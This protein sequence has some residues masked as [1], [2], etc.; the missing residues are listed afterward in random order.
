MTGLDK[1]NWDQLK[2]EGRK[3]KLRNRFIM[4]DITELNSSFG[5]ERLHLDKA[6]VLT[7]LRALSLYEIKIVQCLRLGTWKDHAFSPIPLLV[8]VENCE[9]RDRIL[10]S[11]GKLRSSAGSN[12]WLKDVSIQPDHSKKE[13]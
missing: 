11:A 6:K 7:V 8:H 12:I 10:R 3:W 1:Y 5:H 13:I 4:C 2:R 9:M